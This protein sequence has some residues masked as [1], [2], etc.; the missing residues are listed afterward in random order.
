MVAVVSPKKREKKRN[1]CRSS[2][3][4][5]DVCAKLNSTNSIIPNGG[6]HVNRKQWKVRIKSR[7]FRG[8]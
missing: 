6:T 2:D 5:F 3:S 8:L 7:F 1:S 4:L